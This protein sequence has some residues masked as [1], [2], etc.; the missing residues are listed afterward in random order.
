MIARPAAGFYR[1]PGI[2]NPFHKMP[3]DDGKINGLMRKCFSLFAI[4]YYFKMGLT[5]KMITKVLHP[6]EKILPAPYHASDFNHYKSISRHACPWM[7]KK[8][9]GV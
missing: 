8:R 3:P 6:Y 1:V 4:L 5:T 2:V 7:V 9:M